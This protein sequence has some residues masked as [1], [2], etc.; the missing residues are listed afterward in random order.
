MYEDTRSERWE[1]RGGR[2]GC[3][4]GV[5]SSEYQQWVYLVCDCLYIWC[6]TVCISGVCWR[7]LAWPGC[8]HGSVCLDLVM[9][10]RRVERDQLTFTSSAQI[11]NGSMSPP[12]QE[13][14]LGTQMPVRA[15]Y[16]L[17]WSW[18]LLDPIKYSLWWSGRL[19]LLI[20]DWTNETFRV[21]WFLRQQH[22]TVYKMG[23][24]NVT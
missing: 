20:Q 19:V 23:G 8:L 22:C 5:V 17:R 4:G 13:L 12:S 18:Q 11:H 15:W 24:G 2:C 16:L 7:L 3:V 6:V 21:L 1:V 9:S 14:E 10:T